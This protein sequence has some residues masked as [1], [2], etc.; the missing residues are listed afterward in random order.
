MGVNGNE[1]ATVGAKTV[2]VMELHPNFKTVTVTVIWEN[3]SSRITR[4]PVIILTQ[5]VLSLVALQ[6]VMRE[7][8][9]M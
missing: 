5:T 2:T 1:G 7:S 3:K 4:L 6:W 8:D 9:N